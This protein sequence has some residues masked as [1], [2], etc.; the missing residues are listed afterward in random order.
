[1]LTTIFPA[2]KHI[3]V[4]ALTCATTQL[5]NFAKM[6][7]A[8][9]LTISEGLPNHVFKSQQAY[10]QGVL[11]LRSLINTCKAPCPGVLNL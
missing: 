7:T 2:F 5:H 3:P 4:P 11:R 6:K 10:G 8:T 1:M 9:R